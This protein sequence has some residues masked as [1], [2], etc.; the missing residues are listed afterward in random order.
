MSSKKCFF[1]WHLY[2]YH[3]IPTFNLSQTTNFRLFRTERYA[4]HNLKFVEKWQKVLRTGRKHNGKMRNCSLPTISPFPTVFSKIVL[5][6]SKNQ[7][8]VVWERVNDPKKKDF[9][10]HYEKGRNALI[11]SMFSILSRASFVL[12]GTFTFSSADD[13]NL[14]QRICYWR[15]HQTSPIV[16]SLKGKLPQNETASKSTLCCEI[17]QKH[18]LFRHGFIKKPKSKFNRNILFLGDGFR[19]TDLVLI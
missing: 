9:W 10:K 7:G 17:V 18:S 2:L 14:D 8:H 1:L 16:A 6:T 15:G 4:E 13:L 3:K 5:K 19:K 11:S 12:W